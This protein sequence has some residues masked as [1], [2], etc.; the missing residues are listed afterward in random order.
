MVFDEAEQH[1]DALTTEIGENNGDL[2]SRFPV[3]TYI[4]YMEQ[5]PAAVNYKYRSPEVEA[6]CRQIIEIGGEA[7]LETY[8]KLL[9]ASL[10]ALVPGK[11]LF[12]RL[13]EDIRD[14]CILNFT[15]ILKTIKGRAKKGLCLYSSEKF[16]KNLG[17][18]R[19]HIIPLGAQKVYSGT[20]SH[21]IIV[22]DGVGQFL[23]A[24]KMVLFETCGFKPIYRM[25][26]DSRDRDLMKE[27]NPEGWERF[28]RRT[29]ELLKL[30]PEI[31]GVCGSSWFF[32][33]VV[34]EISPELAYLRETTERIGARIFYQGSTEGAV[35]DALFMSAQR[36]KLYEEG[37]YQPK[38]YTMV[39][40]R[41]KLIKWHD[42]TK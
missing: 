32:D 21:G 2:L 28:F 16:V 31:K 39:L 1:R 22:R 33:P 19:L 27:F 14:I 36:Q 23:K 12:S 40:P 24:L 26:T 37:K 17:V 38:I 29:A 3:E 10:I 34:M 8:H 5:Y 9:T 18:C 20:M 7:L 25:H 41:K 11:P 4:R 15:R 30:H 35:K 13:P 42:E 6:Y